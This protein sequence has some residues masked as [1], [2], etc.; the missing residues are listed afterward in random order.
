MDRA[1]AFRRSNPEA[2][3]APRQEAALIHEELKKA[4]GGDD[5]I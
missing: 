1:D 4:L 2:R 3:L 5:E